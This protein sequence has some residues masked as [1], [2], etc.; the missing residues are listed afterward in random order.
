MTTPTPGH[1][2]YEVPVVLITQDIDGERWLE[3]DHGNAPGVPVITCLEPGM[4]WDDL[5][6]AVRAH[7]AAHECEAAAQPAPRDAVAR[8]CGVHRPHPGHY[9]PG[10]CDEA[11]RCAPADE[12]FA[13]AP[14]QPGSSGEQWTRTELAAALDRFYG[15]FTVAGGGARVQGQLLGADAEEFARVLHA[16]LESA[17]A[18]R[19]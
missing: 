8:W 13:G 12:A 2:A 3:C 17:R 10:P 7:L 6:E 16:G 19:E 9:W 5:A 18:H 15:W 14:V 4:S 1:A 11:F